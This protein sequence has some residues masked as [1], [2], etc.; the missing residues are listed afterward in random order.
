M[1]AELLGMTVKC[2]DKQTAE[3]QIDPRFK[4]GMRNI[5]TAL[6]VGICLLFFQFIGI[7]DGI[8]AAIAAIICMKSSLENSIQTGVERIIGTVIGAVLGV[9][10]LLI[11]ER[12]TFQITTLLAI[13]GV[14]II[15][16]LC[17]LFK[18]QASTVIGLVVF[19][20]ILIAEEDQPPVIYGT[21][22]LIETFFGIIVAYLINRF[23]DLRHLRKL[24]KENEAATTNI[25]PLNPEE[26]PRIM[27]IW[28]ESNM[29]SHPFIDS[30]YWHSGYDKV[31][32][33]LKD[34]AKVFVYIDNDQVAGFV[35]V[36]ATMNIIALNVNPR[37]QDQGI[38][39]QLIGHCQEILPS[40]SIKVFSG[41]GNFV[42][43]LTKS[44]FYIIEEGVDSVSNANFYTMTWS[45]KSSPGR[46]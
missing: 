18:V 4:I 6:S 43:I 35:G 10:A 37:L 23:F 45:E 29:V 3:K 12:T 17:N 14:V 16:Y 25:R 38:E 42:D 15:I 40:L 21:L 36:E 13:T 27:A 9:L 19:L 46:G 5:K 30:F 8:Q 44:G 2:M 22:R 33:S 24:V 32:N 11:I 7:G 20:I 1:V 34:S 28:L 26:L 39:Q 41:N 31:R